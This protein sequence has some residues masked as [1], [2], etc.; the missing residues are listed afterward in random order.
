MKPHPFV[1]AWSTPS[2]RLSDGSRKK[3]FSNQK[4][5]L[6]FLEAE[7]AKVS[8]ERHIKGKNNQYLAEHGVWP[9]VAQLECSRVVR[10]VTRLFGVSDR[11][12]I[13]QKPKKDL[14]QLLDEAEKQND[15]LMENNPAFASLF[16]Q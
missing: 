2:V 16:G 10:G 14:T 13:P 11:Y 5:A 12:I 8:Y 6:D 4:E 7:V 1:V 3:E 15:S 9:H